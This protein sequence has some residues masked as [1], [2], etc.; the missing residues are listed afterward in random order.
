ML[1]R[2]LPRR[3]FAT[4]SRE[5]VF[6]LAH[7]IHAK[8][9]DKAAEPTVKCPKYEGLTSELSAYLSPNPPAGYTTPPRMKRP[10]KIANNALELV[11]NTPMVRLD[12]LRK[13]LN[14]EAELLGKCEYYSA[15]GSVKDRIALRM[16]RDAE[17][18]GKL[19]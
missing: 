9:F 19:K 1:L 17:R 5:E 11:G 15:G 18:E 6:A 2:A 12:R 14:I 7:K 8:P 3:T 4:L 13:V 10:T 16:I